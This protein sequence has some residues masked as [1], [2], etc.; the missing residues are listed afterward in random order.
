M[1]KRGR[2]TI[3]VIAAAAGAAAIAGS[4]IILLPHSHAGAAEGST[5]SARTVSVL[6]VVAASPSAGTEGVNGA[7]P[8]RLT[9]AADVAPDAP[10]PH[11]TPAIPGSWQRNGTSLVFTPASGFKP[12]THVTIT[13]PGQ[14][15]T[16]SY[17]T[18]T[19]SLLRL[20]QLLGQLGYLPMSWAASPAPAAGAAAADATAS[21]AAPASPAPASPAP[22]GDASAQLSAAYEPPA[23]TFSFRPGYPSSLAGFWEPGRMNLVTTGAIMAFES[24][25]GMQLDGLATPAV[26]S[27]L[28]HAAATDD[29]NPAGYSYAIASKGDPETLT[30]WHDGRRVFRSLANTGIPIDPTADGTY[31]VYLKYRFQ[32]MQGFNPDGSHYADPVSWVSYFHN[33]EA[34]HYFPRYSYG[35]QQSLGCVE[36]PY[37]AAEEAW[38]YLTYGTLVTVTG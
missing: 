15:W 17:T 11:I 13:V 25:H 10:L 22:A 26:W 1:S 6:H 31:P 16:A 21:P 38:P 27:A 8:I 24:E 2:T 23:G 3:T 32:V 28:L 19:Y 12:Q 14:T 20:Q 18:G 7:A 33:G 35:W 5:G 29:A 36:L 4:A 30:I 9:L 34:V 37:T